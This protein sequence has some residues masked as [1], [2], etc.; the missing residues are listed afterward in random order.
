MAYLDACDRREAAARTAVAHPEQLTREPWAAHLRECPQCRETCAAL[1]Q[2]L[3]VFRQLEMERLAARQEF[4]PSW[5][6]MSAVL[7]DQ[8]NPWRLARRYR[9]P[10]AAAMGGVLLA[11]GAG[12][13]H[14]QQGPGSE[15]PARIVRLEPHQQRR[16]QQIVQQ[17][18]AAVPPAA[19]MQPVPRLSPIEP[20]A[21]GDTAVESSGLYAS[22][23]HVLPG[24]PVLRRNHPFLEE[25]Q[26]A[27]DME[28]P[29]ARPVLPVVSGRPGSSAVAF[30][31]YRSMGR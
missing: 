9:V 20:I 2:S 24:Q 3:A 14:S 18:L 15:T 11:V 4:G 23:E 28:E 13:W 27:K 7:R 6:R 26:A 8:R 25:G 29:P 30:P 10:V 5:E 19:P 17:S 12:I 22:G 31:V 16:M 1:A 21:S